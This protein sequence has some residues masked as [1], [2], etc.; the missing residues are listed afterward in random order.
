[1]RKWLIFLIICVSCSSK[2]NISEQVETR[3]VP[4]QEEWITYEGV[5]RSEAGNDVK[6]E[7]SLLQN[8]AGMESEYKTEEE[9]ISSQ[10]H[11]LLTNRN[12]TYSI[13]YGA[14]TDMTI[15]LH[16]GRSHS[17][18]WEPNRGYSINPKLPTE[19][20]LSNAETGKLTFKTGKNSDELVLV[21]EDS[22]PV[23]TDDR[24][25][26]KKRSILFTVEGFVTLEP[27]TVDFFEFNT[28]TDWTVAQSG[29]F[30]EVKK[31][32]IELATEKHEGI[33]LKAVAFYINNIDTT[34]AEVKNLVIKKIITMK[35]HKDN[36][37]TR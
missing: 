4:E 20:L 18:G 17:L 5:V 8:S 15:T 31:K 10:D 36:L 3:E 32:Y 6:M 11:R 23:S 26:L 27:A 34:G 24:Y 33:Y 2:E 25:T 19:E 22:N 30:G 14:G 1:M 29:S 21:D 9:F 35:S 37:A 13:L 7:L 28:R 12:G 16:E